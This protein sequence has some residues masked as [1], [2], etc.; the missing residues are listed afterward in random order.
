[1]WGAMRT[2]LLNLNPKMTVIVMPRSWSKNWLHLWKP[3]RL[4]FKGS[5]PSSL[6]LNPRLLDRNS[7]SLVSE[8]RMV[9]RLLRRW[10]VLTFKIGWRHLA[11]QTGPSAL[12]NFGSSFRKTFQSRM[13]GLHGLIFSMTVFSKRLPATKLIVYTKISTSTWLKSRQPSSVRIPRS[14][15]RLSALSSIW[16]VHSLLTQVVM[17][18]THPLARLSCLC[19]ETSSSSQVCYPRRSESLRKSLHFSTIRRPCMRASW[20][21]WLKLSVNDL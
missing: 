14:C 12:S 18:V 19:W 4:I 5:W 1:M 10:M 15:S 21:N 13:T 2:S 7:S 11:T 9:S 3:S 8:A 6:M 20:S 16:E 17:S